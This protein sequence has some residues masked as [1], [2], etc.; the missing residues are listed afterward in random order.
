MPR[1]RETPSKAPATAGGG[2]GG[3]MLGAG[4]DVWDAWK[5]DSKPP[6]GRAPRCTGKRDRAGPVARA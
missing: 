6:A 2:G 1:R 4:P 3:A 5:P